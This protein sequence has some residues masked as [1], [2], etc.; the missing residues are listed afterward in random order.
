[1]LSEVDKNLRFE[2]KDMDKDLRSEDKDFPRGQ[3]HWVTL[4]MAYLLT[5]TSN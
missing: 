3:Q 5:Y 4:R 1:M 2:D